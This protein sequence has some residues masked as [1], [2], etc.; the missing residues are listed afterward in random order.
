MADEEEDSLRVSE[1][2]MLR[3]MYEDE[4]AFPSEMDPYSFVLTLA[5]EDAED[6]EAVELSCT[7]PPVYPAAAA[8]ISV[9]SSGWLRGKHRDAMQ[10]ALNAELEAAEM[11]KDDMRVLAA[12]DWVRDHAPEYLALASAAAASGGAE[13][14]PEP[15]PGSLGAAA[16]SAIS[17]GLM[18]EWCSFAALYKDSYCTGPNRFEVM[19]ELATQRDLSI[20]GMAIAGKPGGLV[21]EGVEKDVV[22]FMTLMRTEFF[23]TLNPRGRKL[24]TRLQERWPLDDESDRHDAA[25]A[26]HQIRHADTYAKLSA[27]DGTAEGGGGA[28]VK[29]KPG[30]RDRLEGLL[31]KD[32]QLLAGWEASAGRTMSKDEVAQLM[33]AGPPEK[34][35]SPGVYPTC[36]LM[37]TEPPTRE[38]VDSRRIF[39]DFSIFSG[40]EG[41][42]A[43]YPEAGAL[44][45][46]L[47]KSGGFD[48]MF[49]YR[50][51]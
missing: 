1:V 22:A 46:S 2:E 27:A 21:C 35:T 7:L 23:E 28:A 16:A 44:F 9:R 3:S 17:T 51:S 5:V 20:T 36:G 25:A 19:V 39:K 13:P 15:E 12:A 24:T 50:F 32:T 4:L 10:S 38:D 30:E 29:F 42:E 11:D 18:R 26:A 48:A 40:T 6:G 49:T 43:C 31:A 47:G 34:C 8:S 33:E 45:K 14:E 37:C 41:Y